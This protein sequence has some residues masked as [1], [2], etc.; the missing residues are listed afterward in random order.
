MVWGVHVIGNVTK[1][2]GKLWISKTKEDWTQWIKSLCFELDKKLRNT[3]SQQLALLIY[4]WA[5]EK[6]EV[7]RDSLDVQLRICALNDFDS[8]IVNSIDR[9]SFKARRA[10]NIRV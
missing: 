3:A 2:N 9:N 1:F 6:L 4:K 7:L 5:L 10:S 8:G